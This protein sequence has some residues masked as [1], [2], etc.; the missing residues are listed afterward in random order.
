MEGGASAAGWLCVSLLPGAG[1]SRE[2]REEVHCLEGLLLCWDSPPLVM[3]AASPDGL[4]LRWNSGWEN[5]EAGRPGHPSPPSVRGRVDTV[6]GRALTGSA[7]P[8]SRPGIRL[9]VFT[10]GP[11]GIQEPFRLQTL[12]TSLC[13]RRV[14]PQTTMSALTK[15]HRNDRETES[16]CF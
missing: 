2:P 16:V 4:A 15:C 9:L 6:C 14:C 8:G 1:L 7:G 13:I 12:L 10:V 11:P 5:S 3:Q